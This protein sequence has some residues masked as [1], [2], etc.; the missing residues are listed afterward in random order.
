MNE[1]TNTNYEMEN[2]G[3]E[4]TETYEGSSGIFGTLL[5]VGVGAV[6][7]GIGVACIKGKDKIKE[8]SEKKAVERLEKKGYS[9]VKKPTEVVEAEV[10]GETKEDKTKK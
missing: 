7:G 5:K 6:L 2:E 4:Y 10:V 8:V 1:N 9:V 3:M